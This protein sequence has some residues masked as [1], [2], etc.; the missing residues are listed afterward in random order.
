MTRKEIREHCNAYGHSDE[1]V[2]AFLDGMKLGRAEAEA[3]QQ[4]MCESCIHKVSADDIDAIRNSA[5]DE[6]VKEI[7]KLCEYPPTTLIQI[8]EVN[9]IA[10]KMKE[11]KQ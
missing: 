3:E 7:K 9:K 10:E 8:Q 11:S 2:G 5:I 1:E 4:N 6:F